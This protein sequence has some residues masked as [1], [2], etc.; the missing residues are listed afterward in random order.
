MDFPSDKEMLSGKAELRNTIIA[1][2]RQIEILEYLL[3][4]GFIDNRFYNSYSFFGTSSN[5][6]RFLI[7]KHSNVI[8]LKTDS[9]LIE[10]SIFSYH[11]AVDDNQ[12]NKI[13][14][15]ISLFSEL[16]AYDFFFKNEYYAN[17]NL[18]LSF[19][20][21]NKITSDTIGEGFNS[22]IPLIYFSKTVENQINI[23]YLNTNDIRFPDDFDSKSNIFPVYSNSI[24]EKLAKMINI[25]S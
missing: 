19:S 21:S 2:K 12:L 3:D 13:K 6:K 17:K 9:V 25:I 22:L 18:Y 5:G 16:A 8:S 11:S 14:E 24:S 15:L 20:D 7:A 23:Y 1:R 10:C 4:Y